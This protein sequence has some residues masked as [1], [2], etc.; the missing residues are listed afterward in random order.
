MAALV[1]SEP[2]LTARAEARSRLCFRSASSAVADEA[3]RWDFSSAVSSAAICAACVAVVLVAVCSWPCR[4]EIVSSR[5]SMVR[6]L[7]VSSVAGSVSGGCWS[8]VEAEAD[9]E[10][11]R[12]FLV[13]AWVCSWAFRL[14]R[15]VS[16]V[17][18]FFW[19]RKRRR[20]DEG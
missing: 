18:F 20:K 11:C 8:V 12:G 19:G 14:W 1:R 17:F 2:S 16:S 3:A 6:V 5:V 13:A 9:D 10:S 7:E 15:A 4:L